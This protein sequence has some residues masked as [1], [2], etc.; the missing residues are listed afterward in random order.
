M[1]ETQK[2]IEAYKKALPEIRERVIAVALL[3]A[4]SMAMMTSA[5]FAWLTISRAPEVTA[6][7]TTVAANGNLEIAL[8]TGD[9]T[10]APDESKVG[11]SS[12][13]EGQSVTAAN[14]TWGNL[15]NLSDPSYGLDN[16]VLRPARL[17]SGDLLGSPL[18]G[19]SYGDDGR[20]GQLAS[21]FDYTMWIPPTEDIQGYFGVSDKYGVRAISSVK[22]EA[23]G[24]EA[25]YRKMLSEAVNKNS[26][27]GG[28]Y[29]LLAEDEIYM[30]SLATLMGLYM[31]DNMDTEGKYKNPEVDKEDIKNL[32]AMYEKFLEAFD[33]EAEAMAALANLQLFLKYGVDTTN[34]NAPNYVPYTAEK[35][36]AAKT[37]AE[38]KK[39]GITISDLEG[40]IKDRAIISESL[41]DLILLV[42]QEGD[43][44]WA[45]KNENDQS[46]SDV[47]NRLVNVGE[48]TMG[49]GTKI[50][51]IGAR[52]ALNYLNGT[53]K[54]I[55][56]NGVLY[57][58]ELRTGKNILVK[59]ME[60]TVSIKRSFI[61]ETRSVKADVFTNADKAGYTLFGNDLKATESMND[62]NYA[63]GTAVAEDTYGLAVD[64]W[65][66]TNAED[67]Y[68]TLEGKTQTTSETVRATGT[69]P[70]GNIV[71]LYEVTITEK[72]DDGSDITYSFDLYQRTTTVTN[73]NGE[74][75]NVTQWIRADNHAVV[76]EE[77]L[78]GKT[79]TE[80]NKEIITVT[81]YEGANR[82]WNGE[83]SE[84]LLA[85]DP[86][87]QGNG[88]CYMYYA[89]TPEDQARSLQLLE[90]LKVAFV[91]SAGK[92]LAVAEM[93]T[94]NYFAE[95][96]RVTVPLKLDPS[97][98]EDLGIDIEGNQIYGITELEKNVATRITAIVYLDGAKLTNDQVLAAADIQGKLNIQFGSSEQLVP[99]E[100][101]DLMNK[102][103][104]VSA[105]VD[106]DTFNWDE[107]DDFTTNV[108][109]KIVGDNPKTVKAFFLRKIN[110]TQGS[111]EKEMIFT[112]NRDGTW[113]AEYE[114]D[115]P[116]KY[117][118]RSVE[119]DGQEYSLNEA[120]EV[121]V[122]GF[123][124]SS[125]YSDR[126]LR[127][128][129]AEN[130]FTAKLFL[131]FD[132]DNID[133]MPKTVQGRFMSE[134]Y[135]INVN[136]KRN[137]STNI[138]EGTAT[139]TE[140][141]I[142]NMN[143]LVLDGDYK[144]LD[145]SMH[146]KAD[147][148]LGMKVDISTT[149]IT[150]FTFEGE[151]M[152]KLLHMRVKIMKD[153]GEE[154]PGMTGI[155]LTYNMRGSAT[156]TMD[157]DLVWDGNYYVGE[158]RPG[159]SGGPGIWEFGNVTAAGNTL[160]NTVSSPIFTIRSP[161]P[162]EYY[163]HE[164][165]DYQY[166]P[167]NNAQMNVILTN[168]TAAKVKAYIVNTDDDDDDETKTSWVEGSI[169][170][171]ASTD[172]GRDANYVVFNVPIDADD[173]Q[174]GNWKITALEVWDVL[175]QNGN[176]YTEDAP[177]KFDVKDEGIETKVVSKVYVTFAAGQ[178]KH[179][180]REGFA[181]KGEVIGK[182]MQSHSISGLNVDIKDFEEQPIS[183][184]SD[185][186]IK[187][188]Y[189]NGSSSSSDRGGYRSD[190]LDNTSDGATFTIYLDSINGTNYAQSADDVATILYAG[191][192]YTTFSYK[193]GNE[194][195]EYGD[196]NAN[197]K[198]D[199]T[200][201][202]LP[203]GAPKFTV[204][205]KAPTVTISD[206]TMDDA[207]AYSVDLNTTGS[208]ADTSTY[209][210]NQSGCVTDYIY[211]CTTAAGHIYAANNTQ[212]ISRIENNGRTAW[213]YFKCNHEDV[214]TYSGGTKNGNQGAD[215]KGHTYSYNEGEG[216]PK[217]T[218]ALSGIGN[219]TGATLEFAKSGGGDVVMI[220]QYT[221][222]NR[223]ATYWGDFNTYGTSSY[224][225]TADGACSRF[226]GVMDNGAGSNGSDTK[227]VAGT[228]TADTLVL[229][230][231]NVFYNVDI[232]DI[233][234][235]N[236]Y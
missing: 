117:I 94:E 162:P 170:N 158:L 136:F 55:I 145:S 36:Y 151:D 140:S 193:V 195:T 63:G 179:F 77:E 218:L 61:D 75:E 194:E 18:W 76:T 169:G 236:P 155:K 45:T 148:T 22:Y 70:D 12:A 59:E 153:T 85:Q 142:Y 86:T 154:M 139:F 213:I 132:T 127:I 88:S 38:L 232:P 212:Y 209:T 112:D 180:G 143:Y 128:M 215:F 167:E 171:P 178:S 67:S 191:D 225:W 161:E 138:W 84:T 106:K 228:I 187:F 41:N 10:T 109:V 31:T 48:C 160:S 125:L 79:P 211:T 186:K 207:G 217:A 1:T 221:Q 134:D 24:A 219:A 43:I 107:D 20:V 4:M 214:E 49:D 66:R 133:K 164:T 131:E 15:V 165:V 95:S 3:F 54:A 17:N 98:S 33:A 69:D 26:D 235:N 199:G 108:T 103:L 105:S 226:I 234:I 184:I 101:K 99:K 68:L 114:F 129:T 72:D 222:D 166:A 19:A 92:L 181:E 144:E 40:F 206:I 102:S 231:N 34:N 146:Q 91:N 13:T 2:R 189:V 141:G 130:Y 200:E 203:T 220:T 172:D 159:E 116:G 6:V 227:T 118:L 46:I 192:Y 87:T 198:I 16:L 111:R 156:K 135:S 188:T 174:D 56:T 21:D 126:S 149:S 23:V 5:T 157:T 57:N 30:Q 208:L 177:L 28:L 216:V 147:V 223:A 202:A 51:N 121:N 29:L 204:S 175:D 89:D 104:S 83:G 62:G 71:E 197:G 97:N 9:G 50:K 64:L 11:D 74:T 168:A 32:I 230:Y 82:V 163:D 182:F 80:K 25:I 185:V 150:S 90:S 210:T 113:S 52:A 14:I 53:Q 42:E 183:G 176:L 96:G 205:S 58:F 137:S 47:V 60:V 44:K 123:I 27:A 119:L 229:E 196:I 122:E 37:S 173:G 35:I 78:A 93:D 7:N 73:E 152:P 120:P 65:V 110:S 8:A 115:S 201:K 233:T 100:D 81:G 124:I 224:T 190:K 39:N